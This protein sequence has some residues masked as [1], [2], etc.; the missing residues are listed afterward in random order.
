MTASRRAVLAGLLGAAL[1]LPARAGASEGVR[2]G[3]RLETSFQA[4]LRDCGGD[5]GGCALLD[6][7]NLNVLTLDVAASPTPRVDVQAAVSVRNRNFS[8]ADSLDDLGR[9]EETQPVHLRIDDAHVALYDVGAAGL[10]LR[11]GVMRIRW[12]VG[13]GFAPTDRLN[14]WDLED[15]TAFD[16]RLAS[17]AVHAT[18]QRAGVAV[19]LAVL[20]LF[21]PPALPVSAFDVTSVGDTDDLFDLGE[22]AAGAP[23]EV[24]RFETPVTQPART[25][26]N[27]QLGARV[28]WQ[29]PIGHL[30][31]SAWR[32]FD[33]LPQGDGRARLSGFQTVDRVDVSVP[34][35]FPRVHVLGFEQRSQLPGGFGLWS[36]VAVVFPEETGL[37]SD[38]TQLDQL[39]RLGI[40]E[41]V[42]SPLPTQATQDGE[43]YVQGLVG[44]DQL[45]FGRWY[46]NVQYLRG[47][48]TERSRDD[49]H[50]Y[51]LGATRVSL[52]PGHLDLDLR[53]GLELDDGLAGW[54]AGGDLRWLVADAADVSV[55]ATWLSG[56]AR[57]SLRAF[58]GLSHAR[59]RVAV[60]F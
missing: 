56:A 18:W 33:S 23:P 19:E 38:A 6:F 59:L 37:R 12:G 10:D 60:P 20:P 11:A 31:L 44:V 28:R 52:L 9:T 34:L 51:V 22:L 58:R 14:S 39:V 41:A 2:F 7:N 16:R 3:G 21:T 50:H 29:S 4:G 35:R 47:L 49:L 5:P 8:G 27:V 32:G 46:L 57:S 15:P 48:M 30:A 26:R 1:A 24:R 40:L 54:L 25:L 45:F 42:P 36:E 53:G 13:D 43:P 55:G 17:P